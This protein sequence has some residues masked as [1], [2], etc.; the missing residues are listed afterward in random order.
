MTAN[1][2]I[3]L[4]VF[5]IVMERATPATTLALSR[6]GVNLAAALA[7][8]VPA[9][10]APP[11]A[12]A[13]TTFTPFA[14]KASSAMAFEHP[15]T[16]VRAID[17]AYDGA[18]KVPANGATVVMIGDFK[19][20]D[21]VSVRVEP[22]TATAKALLVESDGSARA[23]A[24]ALTASERA[25][26]DANA[27][28]GVIG[29]IENGRSGTMAF[30][31]LGD[32]SERVDEKTKQ[33]YYYYEYYTDVCRAKIEEA[34]GGEKMC[35]GPKGDILDSI[36]RRSKIAVTFVGDAAVILH[37]S[38]VASRFD[39]V[40]DIINRAVDSFVLLEV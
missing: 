21:T 31:L 10:S 28:F 7:T 38:A 27:A 35:I 18:S 22:L 17:R 6:R 30:E 14:G 40:R 5:I 26:V 32:A 39:E 13:V 11:A 4:R 19:T 24:E 34:S 25:S 23:V 36:Q 9:A 15:S 3:A 20:I 2:V 8:I 16:W 29:G 33:K 37:A 12:R 1:R